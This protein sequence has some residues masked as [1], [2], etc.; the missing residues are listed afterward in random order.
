M[1]APGEVECANA[2]GLLAELTAAARQ[3]L[4]RARAEGADPGRCHPG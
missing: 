4:A 3:V 2:R 1:L